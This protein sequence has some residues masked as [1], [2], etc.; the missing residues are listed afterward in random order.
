MYILILVYSLKVVVYPKFSLKK[1]SYHIQKLVLLQISSTANF[2]TKLKI[3][4]ILTTDN[5]IRSY[6]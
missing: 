1:P 5:P 4:L 6:S 2:Y 3:K